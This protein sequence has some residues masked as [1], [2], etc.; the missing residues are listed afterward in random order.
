MTA[1]GGGYLNRWELFL[2]FLIFSWLFFNTAWVA[3]DAFISF[4]SVDNLLAGHGPVWNVGER[5]QVY[6]HPLWYGLLA[7]GKAAG[8]DLFYFAVFLSYGISLATLAFILALANKFRPNKYLLFALLLLF[9]LSRALIDYSSSGLENPLLHLLLM[10]YLWLWFG[11]RPMEQKYFRAMLLFGLIYLTRPDGIIIVLPATA[12]LFI[13]RLQARGAWLKSSLLVLSPVILWEIFSI[14]YYGSPVPN[15]ALAKVN[16]DYPQIILLYNALN[17]FYFNYVFDGLSS[18]LLVLSI[19]AACIWGNLRQRLLMLGLVLQL[20]YIF[21]VGADYMIGRFL[22]ASLLLALVNLLMLLANWPI[23]LKGQLQ[24][25]CH[26]FRASSNFYR[27]T[28]ALGLLLV[29]AALGLFTVKHVSFANYEHAWRDKTKFLEREAGIVDERTWYAQELN[30]LYVLLFK[31][32]DYATYHWVP[33]ARNVGKNS[34]LLSC[35]IGMHGW[36]TDPSNYFIDPYALAEPYLARLPARFDTRIGHYERAFPEGFISS[37]L[38][39]KNML[40]SAKLAQLYDDVELVTK[41]KDLLSPD[42]L[43]AI[44]RLN[45]GHYKNLDREFD[46]NRT[47][48]MEL[49]KPEGQNNI[50]SCMGYNSYDIAVYPLAEGASPARP[51]N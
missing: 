4:R 5:V 42:R 8:A 18:T 41:G 23:D 48:L 15:T 49:G 14:I 2:I 26:W 30:F 24:R 27:L 50:Y 1:K 29:V 35:A 9:S 12:Y 33:E 19:L 37:R 7:L 51:A 46:R 21:R 32:G 17:Y 40:K 39:G 34:L 43:A 11:D 10:A 6:T 44:W 25:F 28:A 47:G 36:A 22:S 20:A 45:T 13:Q 31:G 16:I 38:N 3:E